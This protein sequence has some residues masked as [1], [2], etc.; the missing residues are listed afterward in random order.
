MFVT[1]T[2]EV[3][4]GSFFVYESIH[5]LCRIHEVTLLPCPEELTALEYHVHKP[6]AAQLARHSSIQFYTTSTV[7]TCL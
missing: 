5:I 1:I 7:L 3:S 4:V 6:S 2:A